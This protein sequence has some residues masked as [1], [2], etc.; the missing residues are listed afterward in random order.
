MFAL[1]IHQWVSTAEVFTTEVRG[2]GHSTANAMARLGAFFAPFVVDD[3][4]L[5]QIGVIMLVVHFFTVFCVAR[6]P[7]TAGRALGAIADDDGLSVLDHD[8]VASNHESASIEN[9][10]CESTGEPDGLVRADDGPV[11]T[12]EDGVMT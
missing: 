9:R 8:Q 3:M 1:L 4:S 10:D 6:L 12:N 2:V 7:E 5:T 11:A